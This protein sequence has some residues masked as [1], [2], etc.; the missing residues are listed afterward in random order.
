MSK[1]TIP[2]NRVPQKHIDKR[3]ASVQQQKRL[4]EDLQDEKYLGL[5]VEYLS[6]LTKARRHRLCLKI[7][8]WVE[9]FAFPQTQ[10]Q[11]EVPQS[12]VEQYQ[13]GR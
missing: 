10:T 7:H 9:Q 12:D 4:K 2:R 11:T 8:N 5:M 13:P 3:V 6:T 1:P